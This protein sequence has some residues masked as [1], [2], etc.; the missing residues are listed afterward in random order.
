MP[1]DDLAASI[2]QPS[3]SEQR[4]LKAAEAWIGDVV[5]GVGIGETPAGEPCVTVFVTDPT[6]A[7]V[8]AL[9]SSVE[10]LPV[11]VVISDEFSAE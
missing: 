2:S 8:R 7:R 11:D 5:A 6:D 10:G 4:A 3:E 9:P 1:T